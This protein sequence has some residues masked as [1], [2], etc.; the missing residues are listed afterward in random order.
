[1]PEA[2]KKK[3]KILKSFLGRIVFQQ[4]GGDG[5]VYRSEHENGGGE[6]G[7][8]GPVSLNAPVT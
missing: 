8:V 7:E 5:R 2:A 6:G 3:A 4:A 1:V